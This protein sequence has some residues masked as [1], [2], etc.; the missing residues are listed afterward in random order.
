MDDVIVESATQHLMQLNVRPD[1]HMERGFGSYLW[2]TAGRRYLDF[3]QAWAV[4]CL[5]HSPDVLTQALQR[6]LERVVHVGAAF[7]NEPAH[8]LA[9]RLA[10]LSGLTRVFLAC[11]GAEAN[12]AAVKLARKWG[13]KHRGG[14]YEVITTRDSFHGRTLAM[15][16]ASGKPGFDRAF[17]PA[18]EGF[19]KV[20]FGDVDAVARAIGERTVAV[21][22]EPIQGEAGVVVPP[23][24]YL[25]ALRALCDERGILLLLDEVQ[26]GMGRTGPLFAHQS[27]RAL[28]DIMTLGKG[29]GG[30]LP[31]SAML[32]REH[33]ACFELGDHGG[34]FS[35]HALLSAGALA[36]IELLASERHTE[37]RV[38]SSRALEAALSPIAQTHGAALRGRGHLWA[39]VLPADDAERVR[40]RAFALGLLVNAARPNVVRLMPALDV[41]E[42]EIGE[43]AALLDAALAGA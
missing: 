6:Q 29:L 36:L 39:L 20:P 43:F 19:P 23:T 4:N 22:V 15:T 40:D 12:E 14:A 32:A 41:G 17:P 18:V 37:L 30:G 2:D 13:Q 42:R 26:T 21:M 31:I 33:V 8:A 25:R 38:R 27:E 34:T 3:V 11:S 5:G 16:C 9:R 35:G 7:H 24:G 1:V 28:P 10:A